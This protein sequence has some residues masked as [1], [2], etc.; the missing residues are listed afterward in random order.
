MV[1]CIVMHPF[2]PQTHEPV[3]GAVNVVAS[4]RAS[5]LILSAGTLFSFSACSGD[6][7]FFIN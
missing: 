2:K 4:S 3:D 7:S 5:R 1:G 6:V